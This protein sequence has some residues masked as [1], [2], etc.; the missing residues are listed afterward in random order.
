MELMRILKDWSEGIHPDSDTWQ[1]CFLDIFKVTS[2]LV[3]ASMMIGIGLLFQ[4]QNTNKPHPIF[5]LISLV[6]TGAFLV[7]LPFLF[8][9]IV[10]RF[11][12]MPL[13]HKVKTLSIIFAASALALVYYRVLD[14]IYFNKGYSINE[15]VAIDICLILWP[16]F[17][18]I[19]KRFERGGEKPRRKILIAV[20]VVMIGLTAYLFITRSDPVV[21]RHVDSAA[22]N[23]SAFVILNPFRDREPERQAD[24]VLQGLKARDCRQ[25]LSLQT[26]EITRVDYL[27]EKETKY[28]VETW[29]LMDRKDDSGKAALIYTVKRSGSDGKISSSLASIGVENNGAWRPTRYDA[30]Y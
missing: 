3:V 2:L 23:Y 21:Y 18:L 16:V 11:F 15:F 9:G 7:A 19:G 13:E 24:I 4:E 20:V 12:G 29:S 22:G 8:V 14:S 17:W 30:S 10:I 1:S 26:L 27:C 6:L 5:T 28:P 25:A